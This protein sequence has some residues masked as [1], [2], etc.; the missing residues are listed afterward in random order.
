MQNVGP[1]IGRSEGEGGWGIKPTL[2][3]MMNAE[4]KGHRTAEE[5]EAVGCRMEGNR[6]F[7]EDDVWLPLYEGKMVGMYD[8]RAAS[9]RFDPTNRVRRNQPIALSRA[10]HEDAKQ[11][12]VPMFWVNSA[13]VRERCGDCLRGV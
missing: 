5:L 13:D 1:I 6:Y 10:E 2:M 7:S 3:F 12:A 4:M 9:I 8:H 11:F